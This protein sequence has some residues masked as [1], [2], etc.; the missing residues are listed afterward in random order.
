VIAKTDARAV[1]AKNLERTESLISAMEKIYGYNR[2]YQDNL[3]LSLATQITDKPLKSEEEEAQR[4]R[5]SQELVKAVENSQLRELQGI[6]RSCGEHAIISLSTAFETYC[7]EIVQELLQSVPG[8]FITRRTHYADSI[9]QLVEDTE[10]RDYEDIG[11]VLKLRSRWDYYKFFDVYSIPFLQPAERDFV[12]RIYVKRNSFVHNA[13]KED[14]RVRAQMARIG[15]ETD[16]QHVGTVAKK[17]RTRFQRMML[18]V[19][20]Q[21]RLRISTTPTRS[22]AMTNG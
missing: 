15:A 11:R 8:F 5:A 4:W 18:R 19:D 3:H 22:W 7:K 16:G 13:G 12:E 17:M 9:R 6:S 2:I 20:G 21:L 1:L 14:R 10:V